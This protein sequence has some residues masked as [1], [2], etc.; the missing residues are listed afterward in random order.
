MRVKR[1]LLWSFERG[2]IHYDIICAIILAF[3]FLTPPKWLNDRPDY[4]RVKMT[5]A[6]VRLS[7]DDKGNLVYTVKLHT[8]FFP[9]DEESKAEAI[10]TLSKELKMPVQPTRKEPVYDFTGALKAYAL[11]V[12]R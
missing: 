7:H 9:T 3:I 6:N 5:D 2:S 12:E 11:W 8:G 4:M 10:D 1:F